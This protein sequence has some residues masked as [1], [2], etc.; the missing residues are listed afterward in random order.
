M[1]DGPHPTL[2]KERASGYSDLAHPVKYM[3]KQTLVFPGWGSKLSAQPGALF[4]EGRQSPSL[5]ISPNPLLFPAGP[6]QI[7]SPCR[8]S[9]GH[10][11]VWQHLG[12]SQVPSLLLPVVSPPPMPLSTGPQWLYPSIPLG[13]DSS[14]ASS[15]AVPP[16]LSEVRV[17]GFVWCGYRILLSTSR[18][19]SHTV[20]GA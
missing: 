8:S 3:Q 4:D 11:R 7:P 5:P 13:P 20:T 10:H 16:L 1:R 17:A 6:S 18:A 12:S 15:P 2:D 14:S 19:R 9:A